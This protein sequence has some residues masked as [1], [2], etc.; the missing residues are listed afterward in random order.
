[1]IIINGRFLT[2]PIT[3]VQ[4]FAYEILKELD[5]VIKKGEAEIVVPNQV[6]N[7]YNLEF[8]NIEIKKIG[9]LKGHFWEQITLPIYAKKKKG[10]ILTLANSAPILKTDI[11]TIHDL[12]VKIY[13]EYFSK[14]YVYIYR[15]L[16][17]INIKR[18]KKIL[19][20]S[21]FSKNEIL[22]HY[23]IEK[24]KIHVIYNAWQH[25]DKIV[26]N[27]NIL[28]CLKV[29]D[30]KY[31]LGVSSLN[32]NKNFKYII[33]LAKLHQD[34]LFIIV[35]NKNLKVF[36]KINIHETQNL[37]WAGY[38]NDEELKALYHNAEAFVFPSFYEGFG[39]PPLE[40]I[41]SGC[42]NIFISNTSCLP[43]IYEKNVNYINPKKVEPLEIKE[44]DSKKI[45]RKYSWKKSAEKLKNILEMVEKN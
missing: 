19:T 9:I 31:I 4:R 26:E 10:L 37:K 44:V 23:K 40:A 7:K 6:N 42:K 28:K 13:P 38:V 12:Q 30:K 25:I 16:N 45:L 33:E 41:A 5:K 21:E 39:I 35:G 18:A 27:K 14:K 17:Y 24:D 20:V 3:G 32:P 1:M 22:K 34:Y 36:S 2:Q 8:E 29:E 11:T 43:E 15:I